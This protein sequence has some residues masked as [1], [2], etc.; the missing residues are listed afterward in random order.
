LISNSFKLFIIVFRILFFCFIL[1]DTYLSLYPSLSHF[2]FGH[3][4]TSSLA[5][6]VEF[7]EQRVV[8]LKGLR[9][10]RLDHSAVLPIIVAGQGRLSFRRCAPRISVA[11]D[12]FL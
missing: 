6:D 4:S 1:C 9:I 3:F 11:V 5:A 12:L 7:D 10:D 2:Q 8:Y